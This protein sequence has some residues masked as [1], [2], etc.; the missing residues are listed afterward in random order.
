MTPKRWTLVVVCA[1][2]AMLMLD[3]AVVNTA[4]SRIAEDL[5]AGSSGLQWVVDAYT[6]A[7][8][9][10]RAH[11]RIAGRPLRPSPALHRRPDRLHRSPRRRARPPPTSCSSTWRAPCRA[12]ARRSCSPSRWRSSPTRSPASASAPARSPPTAPRSAARSPSARSSAARSRAASTGSGSSSSTSRSAS[13]RSW[14]TRTYVEESR[15]PRAPRVDWLGQATLA[16]RPVPARAR[17]AAR[18]RGRLGLARRSSPS[19]PAPPRSCR[20]RGDRDPREGADA[21]AQAVPQ[22][23]VH[24]R[25]DRGVRRSR[26]RSSRSSSTPRCTSSRCSGCR[27]IEAGLAYLP[28]HG[29]DLLRLGRDR[30]PGREGVAA[31]DGRRRA[32]PRRHRHGPHDARRRRV[33]VDRDAARPA[34]RRRRH[35]PLQPG[36]DRGR[37]RLGADRAERPRRGHERHVPPGRHRRRRRGARRARCPPARRSTRPATSSYVDGLHD[38]LWAGAGVAAIGAVAAGMLIRSAVKAPRVTG[39]LVPDAA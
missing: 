35:G 8:G 2:T 20:V 11:R 36:A 39:E 7:L 12:S 10:G 25:A 16:A 27:P 22:P 21:A 26:P 37:A 23:V 30:E 33:V 5:H 3:I 19:S 1:A 38:A 14:I 17:P 15:D 24:R 9:V 18:Q 29:R 32:G 13:A 31:A 34:R 6:L 28:G 4:L